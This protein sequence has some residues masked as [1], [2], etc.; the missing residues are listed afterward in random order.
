[1]EC[2]LSPMYGDF[3]HTVHFFQSSSIKIY[4][5]IHRSLNKAQNTNQ[6]SFKTNFF[7]RKFYTI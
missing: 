4:S 2:I 3:G 7:K 1:M 6:F 5:F